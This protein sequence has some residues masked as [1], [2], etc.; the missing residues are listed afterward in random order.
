MSEHFPSQCISVIWD[1]ALNDH[2]EHTEWDFT[3]AD[4]CNQ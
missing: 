3:V 4:F 1:F 2:T